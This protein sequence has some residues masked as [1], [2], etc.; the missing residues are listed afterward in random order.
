[1][2][3][4]RRIWGWEDATN[5]VVGRG[6]RVVIRPRVVVEDAVRDC[7]AVVVAQ[8]AYSVDSA[9]AMVDRD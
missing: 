3:I 7:T 2:A 5:P 1:M 8:T 9:G 4:C 6:E